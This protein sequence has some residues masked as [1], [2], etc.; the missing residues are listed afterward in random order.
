[1]LDLL[2]TGASQR[3]IATELTVPLETVHSHEQYILRKRGVHS[4]AAAIVI[5]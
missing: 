2:A 5:A 4:W 3:E 1:V